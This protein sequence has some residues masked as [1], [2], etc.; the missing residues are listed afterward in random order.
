L[1]SPT[2]TQKTRAT[3]SAKIKTDKIDAYTL[4]HF[5]RGGYIPPPKLYTLMRGELLELRGELVRYRVGLVRLR[6]K[7]KNRVHAILLTDAQYKD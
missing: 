4:A 5:L 3:A 7:V 2:P 1:C 6:T